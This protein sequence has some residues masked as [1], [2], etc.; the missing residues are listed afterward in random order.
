MPCAIRAFFH[1]DFHPGNLFVM[2]SGSIGYVDFGLCEAWDGSMRERMFRYFVAVY[3]GDVGRM[4]WV[5]T[6]ILVPGDETDMAAFRTDFFAESRCWI[7]GEP[8]LPA[9]RDYTGSPIAQE[10]IAGDED[11]PPP[12]APDPQPGARHLP[13]AAG[14]VDGRFRAGGEG[15]RALGRP[16]L[17]RAAPA[18]PR[19]PRTRAAQCRPDG[20]QRDGPRPAPPVL[21][22]LADGTFALNIYGPRVARARNWGVRPVASSFLTVGVALLITAIPA[23]LYLS[24]LIQWRRLR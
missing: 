13:R 8:R 15:R 6:K 17:L 5:L 1:A 7:G 9:A 16:R 19:P 11:R 23:V 20:A 4:Y 12:R 3:S 10:M 14:G 21:S 24:I 2:P 18:R 22:E